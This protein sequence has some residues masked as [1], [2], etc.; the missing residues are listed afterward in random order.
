M[1]SDIKHTDYDNGRYI[2]KITDIGYGENAESPVSKD[3]FRQSA[4]DNCFKCVF[5]EEGKELPP[6]EPVDESDLDFLN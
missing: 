4:L 5:D 6:F 2:F 3:E 1:K